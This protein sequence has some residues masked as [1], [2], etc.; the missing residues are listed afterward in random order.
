MSRKTSFVIVSA[1]IPVWLMSF[2]FHGID[3][4]CRTLSADGVPFGV[5]RTSP[6][7]CCSSSV[8]QRS[9]YIYI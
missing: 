8:I 6:P 3:E 7:A 9:A 5:H 1:A 2:T 4:V